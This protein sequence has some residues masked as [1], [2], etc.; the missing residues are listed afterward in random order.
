VRLEAEQVKAYREKGYLLLP[1]VF[2]DTAI[3]RLNGQLPPLLA[4]DSPRRVL[5]RDGNTVRSLYGCH[6]DNEVFQSFTRHPAVLEPAAQLLEQTAYVY[7]FKINIKAA[8]TG[9][10][11]QWHQDLIYWVREDGLPGP[12][13]LNVVVFLDDVTEVNG[14]MFVVPGSQARGIIETPPIEAPPQ[15]RRSPY[16]GKPAWITNLI[17]SIKYA[18]DKD[19]LASMIRGHGIESIKGPKGS[20]LIFDAC[21]VH[22]SPPNL[23][24]FDRRMMF[25]SY[26]GTKNIPVPTGERRPDFIVSRDH[27]ALVPAVDPR[28]DQ[29]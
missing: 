27:R 28:F 2:S 1:N 15:E 16:A 7:Q 19:T 9:D 23:S 21:L 8:F 6:L 4:D 14:P 5:E 11:W 12:H 20:V 22:S 26:N 13:I 18:I 29:L 25:L 10:V 3:E 17:A 24:P